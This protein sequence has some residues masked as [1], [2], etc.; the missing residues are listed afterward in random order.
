MFHHVALLR[1]T[2]AADAD[3]HERIQQFCRRVR[4]EVPDVLTFD[5]GR[6]LADRARGYDWAVLASFPNARAHDVYQS[7][8]THQEM[9]AYMAPFIADLVVCDFATA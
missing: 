7:A 3:F 6:N 4:A 9:K 1:L 5:F 8:P 2:D